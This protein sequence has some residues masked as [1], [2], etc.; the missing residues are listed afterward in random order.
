MV[1]V[2]IEILAGFSES[3]KRRGDMPVKMFGEL[4]QSLRKKRGLSLREYCR[5]YGKDAGT[6]SKIERGLLAPPTKETELT[7]MAHSLGLK[8]N[9]EEWDL[10]FTTAAVSAGKIPEKIMMD[11]D[12]LPHLPVL[13]RT[14]S[15]EKLSVEKL[16]AI[17]EVI[18]NL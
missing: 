4:F 10:F 18:K 12:V 3:R 15:G 5:T 8:E 17:I 11:K 2:H 9:M 16:K 6:M 13:L 7:I 14:V 1:Y